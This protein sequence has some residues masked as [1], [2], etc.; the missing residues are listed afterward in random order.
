[1]GSDARRT[2]ARKKKKE[3]TA[4]E[5]NEEPAVDSKGEKGRP[6]KLLSLRDAFSCLKLELQARSGDYVVGRVCCDGDYVKTWS[7]HQLKH[8]VR[9]FVQAQM[10]AMP[11]SPFG[12][13]GR[14]HIEKIDAK[15]NCVYFRV[16]THQSGMLPYATFEEED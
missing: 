11:G 10:N 2:A 13:M 14:V 8:L 1:M 12:G 9:T 15:K 7:E 6:Q 4:Y 16:A 5:R 3:E